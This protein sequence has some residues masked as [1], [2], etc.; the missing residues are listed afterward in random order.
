MTPLHCA[1]VNPNPK[2]LSQLL[3]VLPEYSIVDEKSRRLVHY[4][5]ACTGTGPLDFLMKRYQLVHDKHSSVCINHC[6][7]RN[8]NAITTCTVLSFFIARLLL[9]VKKTIM[10]VL[11]I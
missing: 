6:L 4:A 9:F 3:S 7:L 10:I 11:N 1:A 8:I 2:Y 5:A